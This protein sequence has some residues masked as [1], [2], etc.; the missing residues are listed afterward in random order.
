LLKRGISAAVTLCECARPVKVDVVAC[1]DGVAEDE[2]AIV[3][4]K[5][6]MS[7]IERVFLSFRGPATWGLA[8]SGLGDDPTALNMDG[9]RNAC[10]LIRERRFVRGESWYE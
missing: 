10:I 4:S 7:G 8:V 3:A 1:C 6:N 5:P 9:G 2:E